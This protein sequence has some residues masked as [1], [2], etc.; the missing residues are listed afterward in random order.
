M[1]AVYYEDPRQ[2]LVLLAPEFSGRPLSLHRDWST[3]EQACTSAVA[4]VAMVRQLAADGVPEQLTPG[5]ESPACTSLVLVTDDDREN[6]ALA[7]AA[8]VRAVLWSGDE[9][10]ALLAALERVRVD[11][12]RNATALELR[13]AEGLPPQLRTVLV[14][15]FL[16]GGG[17]VGIDDLAEGAGCDRST[18]N[19]Q[20]RSVAGDSPL[21]LQD[22]LDWLVLI[23]AVRL[24]ARRRKWA[25]VAAEL[26]V[27]QR[28]LS[29]IAERL[30]GMSLPQA[31]A[32]GELALTTVLRG[33]LAPLLAARPA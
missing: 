22:V 26:G 10:R 18:L 6:A 2:L 8:P 29:R 24:Q 11:R 17:G 23:D 7:K 25:G 1:M 14:R 3:F 5:R 13:E 12:D 27:H 16:T 15:L 33:N 19:R 28:T 21:R 20:W 31:A 30:A 4:S 9:P 32:A